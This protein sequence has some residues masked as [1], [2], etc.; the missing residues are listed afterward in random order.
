MRLSCIVK[1]TVRFGAVVNPTARFGAVPVKRFVLRCGANSRGKNRTK[2]LFSTVH[3][4]HYPYKPVGQYTTVFVQGT[5]C[6]LST[7]VNASKQGV[8]KKMRN[9]VCAI[10]G[11][12]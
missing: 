2:P 11:H 5:S 3:R 10:V 1:L 8:K 12:S 4:M 9:R 6:V 7:Q